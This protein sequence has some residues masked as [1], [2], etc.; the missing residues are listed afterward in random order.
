MTVWILSVII[1]VITI[2]VMVFWDLVIIFY[3]IDIGLT[4]REYL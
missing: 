4:V 1:T 3:E 2:F